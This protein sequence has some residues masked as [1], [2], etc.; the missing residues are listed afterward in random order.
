MAKEVPVNVSPILLDSQERVSIFGFVVMNRPTN[1]K[2]SSPVTMVG[3]EGGLGVVVGPDGVVLLPDSDAGGVPDVSPPTVAGAEVVP[4]RAVGEDAL[5][6][7]VPEPE[8]PLP[9]AW[10]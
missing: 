2:R 3:A 7:L 8:T 1:V 6:E 4:V 10:S 9:L 5:E